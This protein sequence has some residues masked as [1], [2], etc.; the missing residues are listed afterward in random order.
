[1]SSS[2]SSSSQQEPSETEFLKVS[3][4][5]GFE[6][7]TEYTISPD[8][9]IYR[10]GKPKIWIGLG[11]SMGA[12][13]PR[14]LG[15]RYVKL[16]Q[17]G[18]QEKLYK[19]AVDKFQGRTELEYEPEPGFSKISQVPGYEQFTHYYFSG[20]DANTN[21]KVFHHSKEI[22]WINGSA[23]LSQSG[24]R[25][26]LSKIALQEFLESKEMIWR[27][28]SRPIEP[29]Y[30][31]NIEDP[32]KDERKKMRRYLKDFRISNRGHIRKRVNGEWVDVKYGDRDFI[33]LPSDEMDE[34]QVDKDDIEDFLEAFFDPSEINVNLSI[35]D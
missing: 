30:P 4:M 12:D 2:D 28:M 24:T 20:A 22:K 9:D 13:I 17:K 1:M 6:H 21:L 7:F 32:Y 3:D 11:F 19:S 29:N 31:A 16:C 25:K 26:Y 15:N 35:L 5:P 33:C 10:F 34:I 14:A 8:G 18:V 23:I 27:H